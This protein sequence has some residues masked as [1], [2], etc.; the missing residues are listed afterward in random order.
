MDTKAHTM[1]KKMSPQLP[2]TDIECAIEFY[3]KKLGFHVDF[4]YQ[5]FYAG[6]IK[7]G[8]SIHLKM[9]KSLVRKAY[10]RNDADLDILFSVDDIGSLYK[11][12][13]NKSVEITQ[14]L[15][16][17]PYGKEFYIADQDYNIIGFLEEG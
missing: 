2:V 5:D 13:S 10:T 15:R 16:D 8:F 11:D 9:N 14:S 6:I 7:D 17:M 12:L 1:I 3:T 4:L